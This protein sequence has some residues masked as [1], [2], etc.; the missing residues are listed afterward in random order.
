LGKFLAAPC[1]KHFFLI[2]LNNFSLNEVFVSNQEYSDIY[3]ENLTDPSFKGTILTCDLEHALNVLHSKTPM[4]KRFVTISIS[5]SFYGVGFAYYN[6]FAE[7]FDEIIQ[8]LVI[9]GIMK[10][11]VEKMTKSK[12][13]M[14]DVHV[15]T[16]KV[17]LNFSHIG[18]GFQICL[19]ALFVTLVAFILEFFVFCIKNRSRVITSHENVRML[20]KI[21]A[22]AQLVKTQGKFDISALEELAFGESINQK[23]RGTSAVSVNQIDNVFGEKVDHNVPID[24]LMVPIN[25]NAVALF[26]CDLIEL[27]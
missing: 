1:L 19:F 24:T 20:I 5:S 9:G 10:F 7:R 16:E 17:V 22:H 6:I 26:L 18:F 27:N 4:P 2:L 14:M 25:K 23:L 8:G 12:W 15:K 21:R 13:N 3:F 11:I